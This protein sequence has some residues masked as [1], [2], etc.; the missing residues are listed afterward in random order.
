MVTSLKCHDGLIPPLAWAAV[1]QAHSLQPH[2]FRRRH[3]ARTLGTAHTVV[4]RRVLTCGPTFNTMKLSGFHVSVHSNGRELKEH[5][6]EISLDGKKAI[7]WIPSQIG[8]VRWVWIQENEASDP[9]L[10]RFE[11]VQGEIQR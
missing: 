11:G 4:C 10:R 8:K 6:I 7:C 5:S 9:K 2:R 3:R 1:G